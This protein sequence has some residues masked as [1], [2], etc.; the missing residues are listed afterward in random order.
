MWVEGEAHRL[1]GSAGSFGYPA[2]SAAA[3]ELCDAARGVQVTASLAALGR[4][5]G[6]LEAGPHAAVPSGDG[7]A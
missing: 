3:R 2:A 4:L 7:I 6:A 5:V 1:L